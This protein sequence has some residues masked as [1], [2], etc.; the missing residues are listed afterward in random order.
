[1]VLGAILFVVMIRVGVPVAG[2]LLAVAIGSL[3]AAAIA[4]RLHV[5]CDSALSSA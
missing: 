2:T 5:E 4:W 3:F 1:M